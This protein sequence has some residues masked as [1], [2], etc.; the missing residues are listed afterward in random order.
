MATYKEKIEST[1]AEIRQLK[2]RKKEYNRKMR[3]QQSRERTHRICQRGGYIEKVLAETIELSDDNF[4]KFIDETL[5]TGFAKNK[6]D[7]LIAGQEKQSDAE[8]AVADKQIGGEQSVNGADAPQGND[9]SAEENNTYGN[10]RT[11]ATP[12]PKPAGTT[13]NGGINAGGN[14]PEAERAASRLA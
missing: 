12:A 4:R 14:P 10:I 5:L 2:N 8:N 6:L 9:A 11:H 13:H 7:K 1:E 3:Q